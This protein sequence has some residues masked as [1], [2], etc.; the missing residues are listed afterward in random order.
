[1]LRSEEGIADEREAGEYVHHPDHGHWHVEDFALYEL[2]SLTSEGDIGSVVA[3]GGKVSIRI[4][5]NTGVD[6]DLIADN[7]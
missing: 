2:P 1:M 4:T 7:R 6:G 5:Q 3:S